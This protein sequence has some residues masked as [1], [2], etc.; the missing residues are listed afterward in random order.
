MTFNPDLHHRH[1]IR[2]L[3]YD[4]AQAGAYFVT[5]CAWQ[6]D[7]LF[8]EIIDGEMVLNEFGRVVD[9]VYRRL[10]EHF[11]NINLDEYSIMPNHFHAILFI[12]DTVGAKQDLPALPLGPGG[13]PLISVA[14]GRST[15]ILCCRPYVEQYQDQYVRLFKI[16]NPLPPARSTKPE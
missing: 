5:V 4:Y 7:C 12:K 15:I 16:L 9:T 8:G 6:R 10:L 14:Q 3:N 2:L 13:P 11:T 1:S